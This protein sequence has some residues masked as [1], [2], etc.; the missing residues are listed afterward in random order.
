MF[1]LLHHLLPRTHHLASRTQSST[2]NAKN[3]LGRR[4]GFF[5]RLTKLEDGFQQAA[6]TVEMSAKPDRDSHSFL[7]GSNHGFHPSQQAFQYLQTGHAHFQA[8]DL[9]GAVTCYRQAIQL[10]PSDGESYQYLAEAL[11]HQGH[12]QEA[13]YCYRQAIALSQ[14]VEGNTD[15]IENTRNL[16]KQAVEQNST[17]NADVDNQINEIP[18]FEQASFYLQQAIVNCNAGEWTEAI[19]ASQSALERLEPEAFTAYLILGRALQGQGQ[20][21]T[22][23]QTY[24]KAIA[25]RNSAEAHARLGSLYAAQGHLSHAVKHY[26]T[27]IQIDPNFAG[28]YWK[29]AEVWQQLDQEEAAVTCWYQAF[30]LQPSWPSAT[31]YCALAHRL[32]N[33]GN[34]DLAKE[35]YG[36]ALEIEPTRA[37]ACFGMG[38]VLTQQGHSKLA[39]TYYRQ[40]LQYSQDGQ[41]HLR[42]GQAFTQLEQWQDALLCYQHVIQA[43]PDHVEAITGLQ[44]SYIQLEHW[45]NALEYSQQL[46]KLQP[47]AQNW[48]QLGDILSRLRCWL[49][50]VNAYQQAIAL[51][52]NFAWS[53]NNLGDALLQ[54]EQWQQAAEAFATAITLNPNFA[55]SH[56]NLGEALF[57]LEKWDGAIEH[58][59]AAL[60]LQPDLPHAPGRLANALQQRATTDRASA[61]AFYQQAIQQNPSEPENYHKALELQPDAVE[62]YLGLT[63]ALLIHD[64]CDEAL[65]CCQIARQLQPDNAEIITKLKQILRQRE[66][67]REPRISS[68]ADYEHW[69]QQHNPTAAD[70]QRMK[71]SV[72]TLA[73]QPLISILMPVYNTPKPFLRAAIQS[74]LNQVYPHWE[75]CITDDASSESYISEILSQYAAQDARI[76]LIVH[77]QNQHISAASNSALSQ[78]EGDFIALL[79]HDDL[80]APEALYEVASLLNQHP[81]ADMIYSDEDKLNQQGQRVHPFFKPDWCP[82]SF[83]SRMYTCHLGVYRRRLVER[84]GGFR[85]GYEGSQDYDLVLRLTE[86]TE[87]IFHI[88]KVLYHWRMHPASTA[89]DQLIKPYAEDAAKRA[90]TNACSRRGEPAQA[91]LSNPECPGVYIVRYQ[92]IEY[93]PVSII[94]PTRNLGTVLNR[95]LYSIFEKTTYPNYEVILI[96]NGSDEIETFRIISQW[97]QR[98]PE[99]FRSYTLNI[100]F[101]YSKINNYAANLGQ[102]EYLLFLNNDVEVLTPDWLEAMVEQ[103]Q[104]PSIGAV[105]AL[106]LYPD[107][108]VQHAGVVLG[109]GGIAGH[110]HKHFPNSNQGYFSQIVSVNNYSAVTAACLMCRRDVFNQAAGFDESLAVAFNDVDLCLKIGQLGYRNVY[111]PHVVLY[112]HESKSRGAEDTLEKQRRFR[113]E[114]ETMRQRWGDRLLQDS[115]YSPHLTLEREDYSLKLE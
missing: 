40:A 32:L 50:A 114:L 21:P 12:L 58:Y 59:R 64:R 79:D 55:W 88:P 96:D 111:L 105:G 107:Q 110:S 20:L 45:Q 33:L 84:I 68:D 47:S 73:Y 18:W 41:L 49:E 30:Q 19:A 65:V 14:T 43:I 115:C 103:A 46:V 17:V 39:I 8:G 75:L 23:E 72:T 78:A 10:N 1:N 16:Q 36:Q 37:E 34:W 57:H 13:A 4:K 94:I 113:Q 60:K 81:E 2:L 112:H 56:F 44:Q 93:K 109:I 63:E 85:I 31:E 76:K 67:A 51:D 54:L 5:H 90:L 77:Q 99:R 82:D 38:N 92:I 52:S 108:T 74:V 70:L 104:R 101:N 53:H 7:H 83:L 25:L 66:L 61:L 100:P 42:L 62:L 86:Q 98:E 48:H 29:L 6:A 15:E 102:S 95:C 28:A 97:E 89:N 69:L 35:C 106:L 24:Q 27:A 22:A 80:L 71:A 3:H 91:V 26:Q 87:H 9:A 11:T